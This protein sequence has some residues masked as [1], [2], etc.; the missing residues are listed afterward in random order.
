MVFRV[1]VWIT[2]LKLWVI[3][4]SLTSISDWLVT[5]T[6]IHVIWGARVAPWWE[7]SPPT[8]VARFCWL[9]LWLV[10][11]LAPRGFSPGTPVFP[12]PQKTTFPIFQFYQES[13]RWRIIMDVLLPNRCLFIY[14]FISE[15]LVPLLG[16]ND[17]TFVSVLSF[18][19]L[20]NRLGARRSRQ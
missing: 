3:N 9:I 17:A 6:Y 8:N 7:R 2:G 4:A 14:L 1:V 15:L 13:R 16:V 5:S 19:P 20:I 11:S 12:S 10:L 18:F